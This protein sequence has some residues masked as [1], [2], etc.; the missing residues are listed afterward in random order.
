MFYAKSKQDFQ[1][2][3]LLRAVCT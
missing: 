1:D 2:L 3:H